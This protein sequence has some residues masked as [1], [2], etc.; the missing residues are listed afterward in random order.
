MDALHVLG[1]AHRQ[2][3]VN[4]LLPAELV[5]G[6]IYVHEIGMAL[7]EATQ[8]GGNHVVRGRESVQAQVEILE[9]L[10]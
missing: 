8:L 2:D 5:V 3:Q 6:Q 9:G 7:D 4:Q 10:V 1:I